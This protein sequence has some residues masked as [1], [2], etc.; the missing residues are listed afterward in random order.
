VHPGSWVIQRTIEPLKVAGA[1][2]EFAM[3]SDSSPEQPGASGLIG[4][5]DLAPIIGATCGSFPLPSEHYAYLT[6]ETHNGLPHLLVDYL[7][8]LQKL[9]GQ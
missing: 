4:R 5:K 2:D 8:A 1:I 6:S 9:E 3:I 7:R